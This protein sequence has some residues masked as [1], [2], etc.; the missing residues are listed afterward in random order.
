MLLQT[1]NTTYR[2]VSYNLELHHDFITASTNQTPIQL[3]NYNLKENFFD[4]SCLDIEINS[5]T[6]IEILHEAPFDYTK[7]AVEKTHTITIA[8]ILNEKKDK[9]VVSLH[10][11]VKLN[12]RPTTQTS[13]RYSPEKINKKEVSANDDTGIIKLTLWGSAIDKIPK[14]DAYYLQKVVVKEYSKG[15]ISISSSPR[16]TITISQNKILPSQSTIREL[17][18]HTFSFPPISIQNS[19]IQQYTCPHCEKSVQKKD[20]GRL[21]KCPF[22]NSM[23]LHSALQPKYM[24]K[25]TF[26]DGK[27]QKTITVYNDML[28]SYFNMKGLALPSQF[29]EIVIQFLCDST[30]KILYDCRNICIGFK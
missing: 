30:S 17:L 15:T 11:Y 26:K 23:A 4:K 27:H 21:F 18:L 20:E 1:S 12:E 28:L 10:A 29:D 24:L 5:F 19:N 14:S 6:R 8:K 25:L 13:L 2:S 7:I 3:S 9:D 22:C 16:S